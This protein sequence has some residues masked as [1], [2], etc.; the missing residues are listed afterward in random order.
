MSKRPPEHIVDLAVQNCDD[1]NPHQG[2]V[3]A[4]LIRELDERYEIQ[5]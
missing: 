4:N 1:A 2:D 3:I 5:E